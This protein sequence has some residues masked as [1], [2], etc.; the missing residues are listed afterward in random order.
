M[1]LGAPRHAPYS[2]AATVKLQ[3]DSRLWSVLQP[4]CFKNRNELG[5]KKGHY[6]YKE[7]CL[8]KLLFQRYPVHARGHGVEV[9]FSVWGA[10]KTARKP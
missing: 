2:P 6:V 7:C 10:V 1:A 9:C 3:V 5:N 4:A 8:V